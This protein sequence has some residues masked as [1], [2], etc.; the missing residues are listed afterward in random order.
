MSAVLP[1]TREVLMLCKLR[2]LRVQRARE[3]CV[4][5]QAQIEQTRQAV[6]ERMHKIDTGRRAIDTLSHA[7]VNSFAAAMPRWS[8]V[9]TA[10]RERLANRLERDEYALIGDEHALEQA[11]EQLQQARAELTRALARE[12]AVNDL[13]DETRRAHAGERDR[14]AEREIEDLAPARPA[15]GRAA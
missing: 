3:R 9:A 4:A 1:Q 14:R 11:Q 10:Q 13:A 2:A 5:A 12:G 8:S 15:R 6:L 7:V